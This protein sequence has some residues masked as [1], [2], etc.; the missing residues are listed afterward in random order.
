M[1]VALTG[2]SENRIEFTL[3]DAYFDLANAIRRYSMMRVPVMAMD[4][5]TIYENSS[6]FFDEYIAH[7]LG[8]IPIMTPTKLP[9]N[10]EVSIMLD[11]VG[12]GKFYSKDLKS[13]DGEIVPALGDI[14]LITL[15]ENQSLRVEGKAQLGTG[16]KH[17]KF[18]SGLIS[19]E[20][21]EEGTTFKFFVESM[22][23]MKPSEVVLRACDVL[24]ADVEEVAK[25]VSKVK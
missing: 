18:Q 15:S 24:S 4:S 12:P 10:T 13:P 11:A 22:Y 23:H 1:E 2:S 6:S 16:V 21:N 25:L 14:P 3:S 8:L 5:V 17:A 9:E 20:A 7:R 19:Y